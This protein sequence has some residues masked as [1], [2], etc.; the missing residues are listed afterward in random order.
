MDQHT[1]DPGVYFH[2]RIVLGIILGLSIT[3]LL[4]GAAAFIQHP[5]RHRISWLHLGWTLLMFLLVIHFWWF[6][7]QLRMLERMT[8]EIYV[9]VIGYCSIYFLLCSLLYPNDIAEYAGYEDYFLSRRLWFFGLL[10]LLYVAD[11]ADTAIKGQ[12]Y[13]ESL[14]LEYPA[15]NAAIVV[16]SLIAMFTAHRRFHYAFLLLGLIY[17]ISW[18]VRLYNDLI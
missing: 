16:L 2:V 14:G 1:I 3:R 15:R 12:T 18:I 8:F 5:G 13:F 7:F 17:Q 11:L 9:F 10:A 4:S 6:E